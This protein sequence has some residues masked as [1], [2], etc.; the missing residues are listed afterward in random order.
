[1]HRKLKIILPFVII[2]LGVFTAWQLMANSPKAKRKGVTIE[3]PLVQT[4][5]VSPQDVRIPIITQGT[6]TPRTAISLSAEVSG[7]IIETSA[8]FTRGG[9]FHKGDVLLRINPQ[10]YKLAITRAEATMASAK[11][12]LAQTKATYEQKLKEYGNV[13]PAK[14]SD[15]AL[16]K[17]E[18][19]EAKAKL[20]AAQAD[21]QLA[22]LHLSRCE[23]RAPF[24]GRVTDIMADVGQ[25]TTPG[26]LVAKLFAIDAV[27]IRLPVTQ[28]QARLMNL[29]SLS[30]TNI[31]P[32]DYLPVTLRGEYAGQDYQWH[33]NIV[34][35][36]ASI[37]DRNRLLYLIAQVK[38]PYGM[39]DKSQNTVALATGM[40][41][42][43]EIPGRMMQNIFVLPRT[44]I[45][46]QDTVWLLDEA[47]KLH[48]RQVSI[49][50]RDE[51]HA[52]II[53]GL[54]AGDT[55]ITSPLDAVVDGM[56]LRL[57]DS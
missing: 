26:S 23:V 24:D 9:F 57:S 36:D 37:D 40:F 44:A 6:V 43:A 39:H 12:L 17:P 46:E 28:G 41:V 29:A 51:T 53:D 21:L 15:F 52:Y 20:K 2:L 54:Q 14:V 27:E 13:N 3:A 33:G 31:K 50:H 35:T 25:Y 38:D 8:S 18:Y 55:I 48:Q 30:Q 19:E 4:I 16:R 5:K 10:D 11:Q 7:R 42:K 56:Q 32:E 34:R 1:M 22:Q 49:I 45:H 47:L